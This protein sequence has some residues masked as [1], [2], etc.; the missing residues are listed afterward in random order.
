MFGIKK[1]KERVKELEK[2]VINLEYNLA[3]EKYYRENLKNEMDFKNRLIVDGMKAFEKARYSKAELIEML[4]K[5]ADVTKLEIKA[6][7][8]IKF[9]FDEPKTIL[10]IED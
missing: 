9:E 3:T 2:K 10:I 4:N 1:L 6:K 5:R 8:E 7:T